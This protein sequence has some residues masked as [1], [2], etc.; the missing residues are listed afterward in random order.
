MTLV[1]IGH[2]VKEAESDRQTDVAIESSEEFIHHSVTESGTEKKQAV[3]SCTHNL[4][5]KLNVVVNIF[6]R[7]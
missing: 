3:S 7:Q 5:K 4:Y 6:C 1:N 2:Q